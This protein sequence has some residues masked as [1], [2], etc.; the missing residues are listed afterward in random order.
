M[1][2]IMGCDNAMFSFSRTAQNLISEGQHCCSVKVSAKWHQRKVRYGLQL[3]WAALSGSLWL[4]NIL[5][6]AKCAYIKLSITIAKIHSWPASVI[7]AHLS[8][9]ARYGGHLC[10]R[11]IIWVFVGFFF[12]F[13]TRS[14]LEEGRRSRLM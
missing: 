1:K 4:V 7:D 8:W 12:F 9:R 14:F 3:C 13:L 6:L 2:I 11:V 5:L 10:F